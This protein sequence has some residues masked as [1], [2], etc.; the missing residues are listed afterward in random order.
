MGDEQQSIEEMA[1]H[2][3][4]P[5][6]AVLACLEAIQSADFATAW[7]LMDDEF[8]LAGAQGWLWVNRAHP[9][10]ASEDLDVA[11]AALAEV[12]STHRLWDMFAE[13]ELEEFQQALAYYEPEAY[14]AASHPRIVD[15]DYEVVVFVPLEQ[16]GKAMV[17]DGPTLVSDALVALVHLER[18]NWRVARIGAD[19]RAVPG[20]P[21]QF[22]EAASSV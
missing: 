1:A 2:M 5:V 3:A 13:I 9:L 8:R 11:A 22:P 7:S 4:G 14:G 17:Y 6:A 12:P 19:Q 21:P 16:P 15:L 18:G 20:W 10:I